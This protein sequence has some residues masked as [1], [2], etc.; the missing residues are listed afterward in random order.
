M[1]LPKIIFRRSWL[2]DSALARRQEFK[3]PDEKKLQKAFTKIQKDWKVHEALLLKEI[4]KV[5]KLKWNEKEIVIYFSYGIF[6]YSDPLTINPRSDIHVI[7]HE[8]IH[9][10]LSE[11]ENWLK[12]KKRWGK[13][14]SKYKKEDKACKVHIIIH[15]VHMEIMSKLFDDKVIKK[16]ILSTAHN[17]PYARSW[18]IVQQDGY[19]NI[20]KELFS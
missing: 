7:T 4:S 11:D 10:I 3:N 17:L 20:V 19:K 12:I 15:A 18:E 6:P 13:F 1:K 5:T 8:L 9:R 2:Y 14:M 16:E